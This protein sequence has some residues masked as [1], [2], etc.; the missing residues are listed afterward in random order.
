MRLPLRAAFVP[1]LVALLAVAL[2]PRAPAEETFKDGPRRA[3]GTSVEYRKA[4]AEIEKIAKSKPPSEATG[5]FND[6]GLK[7]GAELPAK[8]FGYRLASPARKTHSGTDAMIFG[9]IEI[10]ALLQERRPG[11]PWLSIGD[12][13]GPEGG[14]LDPHINHQDGQDLDLAF[15]YCNAKGEPVDRGWLKCDAEGKTKNPQA[16][17][18][19]ARNFEMLRLWLESP[20]FGGCEWILFYDGGKKLLVDHGRAL[21]KRPAKSARAAAEAAAIDK[22]TTELAGLLRQPESSPHDDHFHI[23]L[24]GKQKQ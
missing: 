17:F 20:Y 9:L 24:R 6:G 11:S 19:T 7:S 16:V 8:G 12:I 3:R 21:A 14:K 22:V 18:D 5:V 1:A 2:A 13:S 4:I 10:S 23:R 15:L